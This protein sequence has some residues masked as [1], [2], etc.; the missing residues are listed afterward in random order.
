MRKPPNQFGLL[1]KKLVLLKLYLLKLVTQTIS[2]FFVTI[3]SITSI[4]WFA[5]T[6]D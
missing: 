5:G 6:V 3:T 4:C 1:L 2:P